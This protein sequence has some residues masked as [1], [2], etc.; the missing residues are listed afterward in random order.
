M[1]LMQSYGRGIRDNDD[2]CKFYVLDEDFEH[3][4]TEFK[5]LF[6]EYFL[7]AIQ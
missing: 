5:Y 7:E 6:N 4:I 3:L 2:Y 1:P